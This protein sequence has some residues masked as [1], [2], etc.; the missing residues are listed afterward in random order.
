MSWQ[1]NEEFQKA[2][3]GREKLADVFLGETTRDKRADSL[4][5]EVSSPNR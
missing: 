3:R 5:E 2:V 1:N 4:K